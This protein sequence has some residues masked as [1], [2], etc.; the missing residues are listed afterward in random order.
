MR[1]TTIL[2]A[3]ALFILSAG[4]LWAEVP[5]LKA[6]VNIKDGIN[7]L[8][9]TYCSVPT[10]VDWNNDGAKDLVVGQFTNGYI[11]LYLNTGTDLNPEFNGGSLIQSNGSPIT[12]SYS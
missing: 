12:T 4:V 9:V 8:E 10:A 5:D 3:G 6:G 2:A 11:W 1:R 7:D